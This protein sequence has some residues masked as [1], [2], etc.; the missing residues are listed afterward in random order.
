MIIPVENWLLLPA[1]IFIAT[2]AM[3][4]GLGGG[5]LWM[6]LFL[7]VMKIPPGEAVLCTL[8]IQFCGQASA[9][10]SNN[11]QNLIDWQ[12]VRMMATAGIPTVIAASFFSHMLQPLWIKFLLGLSIFFIAYVFLRSDD[13][14]EQGG[15]H[16]DIKAARQGWPITAMGGLLTGFLG[17]GVGDWLVPFFNMRGKLTMVRSVASSIGLMMILS[18]VA[19]TVHFFLQTR[20]RL[21]IALPSIIGVITG[22]QVGSR[23]LQRVPEIHFK[24][25]FVLMLLFLATHVTFNAV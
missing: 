23:L 8:L 16:V 15:T 13:F 9:S 18:G 25:I 1:G 19:L 11:R 21:D 2:I 7:T 14:L 24:E 6:P 17:I 10:F 22:A 4:T 12:L 5:V 3:F 20:V